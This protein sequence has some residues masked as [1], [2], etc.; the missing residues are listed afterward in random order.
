MTL[1]M[2][3]RMLLDS[4]PLVR[5]EAAS[6]CM[7]WKDCVAF[8]CAISSPSHSSAS[9]SCCA[10]FFLMW[11]RHSRKTTIVTKAIPP[12]TPP[13]IAPTFGPELAGEVLGLRTQ[14]M[15]A[16]ALQ[17]AGT[18]EQISFLLHGG[19]VGFSSG[20]VTQRLKTVRSVRSTSDLMLTEWGVVLVCEAMS[21]LRLWC[22]PAA[23]G[24]EG[25]S[26]NQSIV[27]CCSTIVLQYRIAVLCV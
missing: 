18:R 14:T 17:S 1:L 23:R 8:C 11:K 2:R 7:A 27:Q 4:E 19:Q 10:L 13:A 15:E 22:E 21:G 9:R 24:I 26:R 25:R 3:L 5:V 20:H 6:W 16:H 12:T